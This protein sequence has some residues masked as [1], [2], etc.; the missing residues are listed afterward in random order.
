VNQREAFAARVTLPWRAI[1]QRFS[2]FF[3]V[4]IAVSLIVLGRVDRALVDQ[5]RARTSDAVAPILAFVQRPIGTVR[6][7]TTRTE[8]LLDLAAENMRLR[9]ENARLRQWQA[10]ALGLE[11]Q[12]N[13]LRGLVN[14]G[15]AAPPILKTE[16]VIAEPGGVYVRSVLIGGGARDGL[17]KGQAA[18]VGPALAGRLTEIGGWSA[19]VLLIT[20]LN[21]RIPVVLEGTR[22]HAILT[23]DNSARP[24]LKYLP[25]A[26]QVNIGDR[27]VTAGHDGVFPTGLAVG[28]VVSIEN[29]DLRVEPFA[30]LDRL[31]YVEIVD[32]TAASALTPEGEPIIVPNSFGAFP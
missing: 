3:L 19:R 30:A 12:N 17:A 2:S 14:L 1:A 11:A 26:A 8:G 5:M 31:E 28:R 32:S 25:K 15:P 23:G 22:T 20:D 6:E 10:T 24:R 21:S 29:G 7:M 16:P 18:M 27:V 4:L 13:V 9:D